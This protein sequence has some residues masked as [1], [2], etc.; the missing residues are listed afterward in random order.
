MLKMGSLISG[1]FQLVFRVSPKLT[2]NAV[3]KG[4]RASEVF[5]E[6]RRKLWLRDGSDIFVAAFV[7]NPSEADGTTEEG[8]GK[9][10]TIYSCGAWGFKIIFTL[11]TKILAIYVRFSGVGFRGPSLEWALP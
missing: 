10:D 11:L 3:N 7:L 2:P 8:G 6:E 4:L 1:F 9:E 5:L